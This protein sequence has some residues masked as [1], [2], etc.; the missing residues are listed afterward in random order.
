MLASPSGVQEVAMSGGTGLSMMHKCISHAVG[1]VTAVTA[2]R[3]STIGALQDVPCG[4]HVIIAG[5]S[6]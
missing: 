1:V 3:G 4:L 2:A 5:G 6:L